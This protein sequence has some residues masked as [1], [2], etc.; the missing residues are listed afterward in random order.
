MKLCWK[1]RYRSCQRIIQKNLIILEKVFFFARVSK[2][3]LYWTIPLERLQITILFL[4]VL[5]VPFP[6]FFLCFFFFS[7]EIFNSLVSKNNNIV[8]YTSSFFFLDTIFWKIKKK[9]KRTYSTCRQGIKSKKYRT[10][11]H[12]SRPFGK[13]F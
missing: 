1:K 4:I 8:S 10:H 9:I 2:K 6:S 3:Y 13:P 7:I 5:L 12:L 11:V